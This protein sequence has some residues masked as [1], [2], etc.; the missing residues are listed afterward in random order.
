MGVNTKNVAYVDP[1]DAVEKFGK[2]LSAIDTIE[3]VS[4]P[5]SAS[6]DTIRCSLTNPNVVTVFVHE[7]FSYQYPDKVQHAQ[8][9]N[10]QVSPI[11]KT[12]IGVL[13]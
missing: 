5:N 9:V 10:V 1:I 7:E 13:R 8:M 12:L 4:A 6:T 11:L 2:P 3:L